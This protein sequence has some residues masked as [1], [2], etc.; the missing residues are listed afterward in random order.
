VAHVAP[1]SENQRLYVYSHN[2]ANDLPRGSEIEFRKGGN[3]L[4]K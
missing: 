1:P 4:G 2:K 3:G